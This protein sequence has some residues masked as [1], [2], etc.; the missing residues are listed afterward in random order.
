MKE[1]IAAQRV[2]QT[3]QSVFEMETIMNDTGADSDG[4]GHRPGLVTG[5]V[6][7]SLPFSGSYHVRIGCRLCSPC[8]FGCR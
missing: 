6:S 2:V 4:F 3:G 7:C 8:E 1:A 5:R